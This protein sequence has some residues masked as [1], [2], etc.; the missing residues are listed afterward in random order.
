MES[1]EIMKAARRGEP[2]YCPRC[3]AE[4]L[5][6]LSDE[7]ATRLG[8]HPGLHCPAD[9]RHFTYLVELES[10]HRQF[11]ELFEQKQAE[12]KRRNA[13]AEGRGADAAE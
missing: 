9:G 10:R 11:W 12:R 2:V 6:A 3:G 5:N 7:S 1:S 4:L 13:A 8:V